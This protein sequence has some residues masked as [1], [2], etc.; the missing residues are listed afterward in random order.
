MY[1]PLQ[2]FTHGSPLLSQTTPKELARFAKDSNYQSIGLS[3]LDNLYMCAQYYEEFTKLDLKPILGFQLRVFGGDESSYINIYAKNKA[4]WKKLLYILYMANNPE[5]YKA[6]PRLDVFEFIQYIDDN[7]IVIIKDKFVDLFEH[8]APSVYVGLDPISYPDKLDELR[9]SSLRKVVI[10]PNHYLTSSDWTNN[11]YLLANHLKGKIA[12]LNHPLFENNTY[13]VIGEQELRGLG[14]TQDETDESGKI[15]ESI[16]KFDI[17][18]KQELPDF[19]CPNGLTQDEYLRLLC[20][21]GFKRLNLPDSPEYIER[22]K[23]ELDVISKVNMAGYF[24][25][26]YDIVNWARSQNILVGYGRGSA[27]GCIVSYLIGIVNVDPIK[28]N[29]LFERFYSID[30]GGLPD[31]DLDFPPSKRESIIK[32]IENKYGAEQFAQLCTFNTLKG[33]NALKTI[34]RAIGLDSQEQ[35]YITK[36]VP[37]EGK[38]APLLQKQKDEHG[39]S[40]ILLWC[41]NNVDSFAQWCNNNFEGIYGQEFKSGIELDKVICGRGRH[42][43]AFALSNEPIYNKAPLIWDESAKRY[44]IGVNM[45]DAEKFGLVKLD[46]LGLDLLDK[47]DFIRERLKNGCF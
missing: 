16:E 37:E 31:I 41:I 6:G 35:N 7:I 40:S 32:Y 19:E 28:Y 18:Y 24:I 39:T 38:V 29:L 20:R 25:V 45:D 13:Y 43:S 3:D 11:R 21:Q 8:H 4:G 42:P 9:G 33:A 30:R 2:C 12:D 26:M 44:V 1:V 46:L 5:N 36:K 17:F 47:A 34:F 22:I 10:T 15:Y 23:L 14:I 27:A